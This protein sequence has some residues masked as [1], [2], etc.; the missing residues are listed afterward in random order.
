MDLSWNN[1]GPITKALFKSYQQEPSAVQQH[2]RE[3]TYQQYQQGVLRTPNT[4]QAGIVQSNQSQWPQAAAQAAFVPPNPSQP[5]AS[6]S[7]QRRLQVQNSQTGTEWRDSEQAVLANDTIVSIMHIVHNQQPTVARLQ[8]TVRAEFAGLALH[9]ELGRWLSLF[10]VVNQW[11][12]MNPQAGAQ[13]PDSAVIYLNRALGDGAV[14]TLADSL[15]TNLRN[16][17]EDLNPQPLGLARC[18]AGIYGCDVPSQNDQ[19]NRLGIQ[20]THLDSAGWIIASLLCKAAWKAAS[21]VRDN[22]KDRD[23]VNLHGEDA[24]MRAVL[25]NVAQDNLGWKVV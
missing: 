3:W 15:S 17:L 13:G 2:Y 14:N 23:Y 20:Q 24:F 1:I 7:D 8:V 12:V 25:T 22:Q 11:K 9:D 19:R 5:R 10:D 16:A 6:D 21:L 4:L 18:S